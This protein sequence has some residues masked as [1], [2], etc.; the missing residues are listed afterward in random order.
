[1]L[2]TLYI[3]KLT[4]VPDNTPKMKRNLLLLAISALFIAS[5]STTQSTADGN[6]DTADDPEIT[7]YEI[8]GESSPNA[9]G[10]FKF[11]MSIDEV[12]GLA[13]GHLD[14]DDD[15]MI[16]Y[17]SKVHHIEVDW[18]F[19]FDEGYG[20]VDIDVIIGSDEDTGPPIY[21]DLVDH[22]WMKYSRDQDHGD[23]FHASWEEDNSDRGYTTVRMDDNGIIN[24]DISHWEY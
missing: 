14:N 20:L 21:E 12:K 1:M 7:A 2:F 6:T 4:I 16:S 17:T 19:W 13:K 23:H 8:L 22:I 9:L 10:D 3:C 11:G 15:E 5:C 18:E 24:L